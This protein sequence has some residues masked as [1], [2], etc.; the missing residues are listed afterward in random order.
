MSTNEPEHV[1]SLRDFARLLATAA[2]GVGEE[3]LHDAVALVCFFSCILP[4]VPRS[5]GPVGLDLL[6]PSTNTRC[7]V[8][9]FVLGGEGR[10]DPSQSALC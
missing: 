3:Y 6:F 10:D 9:S 1:P 4:L 8:S 2:L 5:T 7:G